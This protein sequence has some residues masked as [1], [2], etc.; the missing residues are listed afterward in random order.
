MRKR[1]GVAVLAVSLAYASAPASAYTDMFAFGDSLSDA[2]NAYIASMASPGGLEPLPPYYGPNSPYHG[3]FT[4]Y[5]SY[6]HFSNGPTWVEDLY[7]KLGFGRLTPSLVG[8]RDYAVAGAE[9]G[10]TNVEPLSNLPADLLGQVYS[11]GLTHRSTLPRWGTL[12]TLDIGGNDLLNAL[13]RYGALPPAYADPAIYSVITQAENNTFTAIKTLYGFGARNILFYEVPDLGLT[14]RFYQKPLQG[15]ASWSASVFDQALLSDPRLLSL[16][17]PSG[18]LK[19]FDLKTYDFLDNANDKPG[20]LGFLGNNFHITLKDIHDPCWTGDF[21]GYA[22]GGTKCPY[23][24]DPYGSDQ[25]LFWD[26]VHPT[27]AGHLLTADLAYCTLASDCPTFPLMASFALGSPTAV[28]EPSKWAMML[29]CFGG[30]AS[31]VGAP[32]VR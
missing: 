31:P 4:S 11:Y 29:V 32:I 19:V 6:G 28:P 21:Y 25:S 5:T 7:A 13:S 8:G 16:E 18:G 3:L 30:S 2:G 15:L 12:F 22:H 27:A 26:L 20:Y 24:L 9:T 23:P 1:L 10:K 14:P 17:S